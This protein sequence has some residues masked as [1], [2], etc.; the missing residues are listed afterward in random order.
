MTMISL[1]LEFIAATCSKTFFG[2][3]PWYQYLD[4][5]GKINHTTC[6]IENIKLPGD[7]S[8]LTLIVLGIIDI[9]LRLAGMIAVGYVIWGGIQFVTSEGAPD[10]TKKAQGTIINALIGLAIAIVSIAVVAFVG[11][12][13]GK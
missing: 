5:A 12:T 7:L 10:R 4:K 6:Q 13:V 9:L 3:P 11:N 8:D 2:I 1:P